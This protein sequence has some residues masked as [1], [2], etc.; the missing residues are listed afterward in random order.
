MSGSG[1]VTRSRSIAALADS[2]LNSLG[3]FALS[4][5]G[6]RLLP[7][8]DFGVL[9]ALIVGT[10]LISGCVRVLTVDA[11]TLQHSASDADVQRCQ[12]ERVLGAAAL[13]ALGVAGVGL[14]VV[15]FTPTGE[16]Q[17]GL[18]VAAVVTPALI[19]QDVARALC[20]AV[21]SVPGALLST[22]VWTVLT[23][24]TVGAL[25]WADLFGVGTAL[26][27]WGGSAAI[28]AASGIAYLRYTPKLREALRW[29]AAV[30]TTGLRALSDFLLTQC[31]GMGGGLL[32]S[33]VAGSAA[34]GAFRLV[35]IPFAPVQIAF[36]GGIALLQPA[37]VICV[38]RG[39]ARQARVLAVTAAAALTGVVLAVFLTL[40]LVP[41]D[42]LVALLGAGWDQARPLLV[43]VTVA[44]CASAV[45]AAFGPY[46]RSIGG[47]GDQVL[48]KA[49]VAPF[50]IVLIGVGSALWGVLG[51][52]LAQTACLVV[53]AL[54]AVGYT[55]LRR[56]VAA[57]SAAHA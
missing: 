35:Q 46:L 12:G 44:M 13:A 40:V 50:A 20:Y 52:A 18:L 54:H 22:V 56:G 38:A 9:A 29:L 16:W 42:L 7:V 19:I 25:W 45:A 2:A 36:T 15:P 31:V 43:V 10:I 24:G 28:A 8:V 32:V 39:D 4:L 21:R 49:V 26:A 23:V 48:A 51:G 5:V 11:F 55:A 34:Y 3:N 1:N 17:S 37:M 14:L 47:L 41:A 27:C 30:R 57:K 53:L 6:A 33:F